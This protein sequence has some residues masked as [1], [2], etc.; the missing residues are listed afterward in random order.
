MQNIQQAILDGRL[1]ARIV[2]VVVSNASCR[3]ASLARELGLPTSVVVRKQYPSPQ[4][5]A[6]AVWPIVHQSPAELVC[7]AGFLSLLPIDGAFAG[8]VVNIHPALLPGFGGAGMHG[9][10]VHEAV[11]AHGCKVSGCTVHFCDDRYDSGPIILQRSCRA[12]DMDTPDELAKRVFQQETIALPEALELLSQGRV[13]IRGPVAAVVSD[14]PDD[15]VQRAAAYARTAHFGQQRDDGSPYADHPAAVVERLKQAGVADANTLA[16]GYLHDVIEDG[17]SDAW[18][19]GRAFAEA[20]VQDVLSLTVPADLLEQA[21]DKH[22]Y[23]IAHAGAMS[24]SAKLVKLADRLENLQSQS[25]DKR[26]TYARYTPRLLKAMQPW[27]SVGEGLAR[28]IERLL[29]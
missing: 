3:G 9:H 25:A 6:Q 20:I 23:Q 19:L 10:H 27:S 15:P 7:M 18:R 13:L 11:L 12:Y 8:R 24:P 26:A 28:E 1:N 2:H 22:E 14:W 17:R 5:Y 16:A 29:A 21:A 4:A